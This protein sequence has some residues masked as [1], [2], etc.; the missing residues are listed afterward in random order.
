MPAMEEVIRLEPS[1][2]GCDDTSCGTIPM[3]MMA[4]QEVILAVSI[5]FSIFI[6]GAIY[7]RRMKFLKTQNMSQTTW[8]L[9]LML[10]NALKVHIGIIAVFL[11]LPVIVFL[12]IA[13]FG[14]EK[15]NIVL[16]V[17]VLMFTC[18]SIFDIPAMFFFIKPYRKFIAGILRNALGKVGLDKF[19]KNDQVLV[20]QQAPNLTTINSSQNWT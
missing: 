13:M 8:K 2:S 1:T 6:I 11:V 18:H 19:L 7:R 9:N 4:A 5:F 12:L 10:M 14:N 3:Y 16:E 15:Y 20:V 17:I